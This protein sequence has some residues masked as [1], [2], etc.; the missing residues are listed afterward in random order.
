MNSVYC[1]LEILA[2]LPMAWLRGL[3]WLLGTAV[4]WGNR[5]RRTVTR[6]NLRIA[7]PALTDSA[8]EAL[9]KRHLRTLGMALA[10]RIWLWF[11]P[12]DVVYA[13]ISLT[14]FEHLPST[15]G[16]QSTQSTVAIVSEHKALN[17]HNAATTVDRAVSANH[18]PKPVILLIPHFAGLE[19]AGPAWV[20]ACMQRGLPKPAFTTIFQPQSTVWEDALFRRG[21]GRFADL[22]QFTRHDGIRPVIKAMR[23]QGRHYYCLPDNDFG[24]KDAVFV[25]FFGKAAATITV[26]PKLSALLGAAV[27]PLVAR[28]TPQGYAVQA[29]PAMQGM[30]SGTLEADCAAMNAA[31]EDWVRTMPEQYLFSHRRYKTRPVGE[32]GVY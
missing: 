22:A 7:F 25:P 27:I 10:D 20:A 31:I 26:L 4:Y 21:R 14:G 3:G 1:V 29:L 2:R 6:T 15:L 11:A 5:K 8:R 32:V 19:A 24:D 18:A 9:V 12:L 30:G 23:Q 17:G 16:T 13:R 28:M